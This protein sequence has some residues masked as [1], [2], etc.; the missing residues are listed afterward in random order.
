MGGIQGEVGRANRQPRDERFKPW[1]VY[2][3]SAYDT[4]SREHATAFVIACIS[5]HCNSSLPGAGVS[6]SLL[7]VPLSKW[8][9]DIVMKVYT[10]EGPKRVF[11]M[12]YVWCVRTLTKLWTTAR[13]NITNSLRHLAYFLFLV[14]GPDVESWTGERSY[15]VA[16]CHSSREPLEPDVL[17]VFVD[18]AERER[19]LDDLKRLS[20]KDDAVT[21]LVDGIRDPRTTRGHRY[22]CSPLLS[23]AHALLVAYWGRRRSIHIALLQCPPI[24][25][26]SSSSPPPPP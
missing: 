10:D 16:H 12:D 19:A 18:H 1:E 23:L 6:L 4:R 20:M 8:H 7:Q 25:S 13:P 22:E 26:A 5:T 24:H 21:V 3:A 2:V 14:E 15:E 11:N 17:R 9:I